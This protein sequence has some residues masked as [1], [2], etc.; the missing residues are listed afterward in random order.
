MPK[1]FCVLGIDELHRAL[2]KFRCLVDLFAPDSVLFQAEGRRL[3]EE[4][5]ML[6]EKVEC[7]DVL[8]GYGR[9]IPIPEKTGLRLERDRIMASF[10]FLERHLALVYNNEKADPGPNARFGTGND[11][12]YSSASSDSSTGSNKENVFRPIPVLAQRMQTPEQPHAHVHIPQPRPSS[13]GHFSVYSTS[14]SSSLASS[15]IQAFNVSKS[16]AVAVAP[17][18]GEEIPTFIQ[19]PKCC[20]ELRFSSTSGSSISAIPYEANSNL[21]DG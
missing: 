8:I 5:K 3:T 15:Y 18:V 6:Q 2:M 12:I 13:P 9:T 1:L 7:W 10:R 16:D 4:I 11:L 17:V 14:S 20:R 21:F 19:K